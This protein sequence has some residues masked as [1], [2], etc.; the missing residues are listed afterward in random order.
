MAEHQIPGWKLVLFKLLKALL[1]W[2]LELL[3][4][5]MVSFW[6]LI[7][8]LSLSWLL[9]SSLLSPS[10]CQVLRTWY[11][12][13]FVHCTGY[14]VS[15]FNVETHVLQFWESFL[16]YFLKF[17]PYLSSVLSF[18]NFSYL[19]VG[20]AALCSITFLCFPFSYVFLKFPFSFLGEL[21]FIFQL[22]HWLLYHISNFKS[23]FLFTEY[24]I[25]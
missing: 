20:L 12:S 3:P 8:L 22:F 19:D 1:F 11:D 16:H 15:P 7:H 2:L 25:F 24:S 13:S 4:R 17:L 14:L 6:L 18:W 5:Y 10:P 23:S 9:V 21:N